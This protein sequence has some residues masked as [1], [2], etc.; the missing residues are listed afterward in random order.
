[1]NTF[2]TYN[3]FIKSE[4]A[5]R[6]DNKAVATIYQKE[7]GYKT[8][9]KNYI[10]CYGFGEY[11]VHIQFNALTGIQTYHLAKVLW[12]YGRRSP[13]TIPMLLTSIARE[14]HIELPA[15]AGI[16]TKDYWQQRFDSPATN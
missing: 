6:C 9:K 5:S 10:S 13:S 4:Y 15:I 12:L 1:M 11:L 2:I 8:F 7:G 3:Q 16:L 14:Y